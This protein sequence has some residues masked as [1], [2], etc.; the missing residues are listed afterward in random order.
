VNNKHTGKGDT[1]RAPPPKRFDEGTSGSHPLSII[2]PLTS[3]TELVPRAVNNKHTGKG[4][5][6]RPPP[7]KR[8]DTGTSGSHPLSIISPAHIS[9]RT[10]SSGWQGWQGWRYIQS[11]FDHFV[12]LTSIAGSKPLVNR[13]GQ[14]SLKRWLD[15]GTRESHPL[16]TILPLTSITELVPRAVNNKHTGKGD[17]TRPPPPKRFDTGTSG[18]HPLS[19]VSPAY[20]SYSCQPV[21]PCSPRDGNQAPILMTRE[22]PTTVGKNL[23]CLIYP[24]ALYKI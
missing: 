6:T 5:T 1:T 9:H 8:F 19:I 13:P 12:L 11:A 16:P 4:D 20:V 24:A 23:A 3:I 15:E 22:M 7:P 17:T 18:S 14:Q 10:H 21:G 2:L